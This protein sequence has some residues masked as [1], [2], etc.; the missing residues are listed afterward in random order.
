[1]ADKHDELSL[2]M[3]KQCLLKASD[4][5]VKRKG[6]YICAIT[7]TVL[8]SVTVVTESAGTGETITGTLNGV[9]ISAG[10]AFPITIT[11]LTVTS[12]TCLVYVR[13]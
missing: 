9:T 13:E 11:D 8:A 6:Y 12:G 4:V 10:S 7:D 3:G 5:L 2:G 1:M